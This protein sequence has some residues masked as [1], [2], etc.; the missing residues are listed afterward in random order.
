MED[1]CLDLD[2]VDEELSDL[3]AETH[4]VEGLG[5]KEESQGE[6]SAEEK[7]RTLSS[8]IT[9]DLHVRRKSEGHEVF[10]SNKCRTSNYPVT[11]S[12][13]SKKQEGRKRIASKGRIKVVVIGG[14]ERVDE[15]AR[16]VGSL[17]LP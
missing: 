16:G 5:A 11:S 13:L 2:E 7:D 9:R 14:G 3:D 15:P 4:A 10:E 1:H 12:P 8:K 17:S 6:A